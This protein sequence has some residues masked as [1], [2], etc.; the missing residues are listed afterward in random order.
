MI[1][2]SEVVQRLLDL[3]RQPHYLEIGVSRGQTFHAVRAHKK[4]AVDPKFL[5]ETPSDNDASTSYHQMTSD[6]FFGSVVA[7]DQRFHVI[8]LDGLHTFE[9]TLR[10]LVNAVG[11]LAPAG[12]VLVD[13]VYPNSFQASLPDPATSRAVREF[14]RQSD[15]SWMGD[16][17]KLV[18][19]VESF[20]QGFSYA[21]VREN[22][23]QLVIWQQ[24]RAKV[25]LRAVE[26]I[27]RLSFADVVTQRGVFE[28]RDFDNIISAIR[29]ADDIAGAERA[30]H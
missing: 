16:V 26:D 6:H 15:P 28:F 19:F 27:S 5:F 11:Y 24:R 14:L 13:D 22:H 25:A 21:T 17:F 20:F 10:D 9:Q 8:Y 18:F 30:E 4:V 12:V 1:S 23:G 3:Y 7:P 2:R 29:N